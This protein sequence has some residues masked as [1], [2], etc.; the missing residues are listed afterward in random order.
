MS[1]TAEDIGEI[2]PFASPAALAEYLPYGH[3][4]GHYTRVPHLDLINDLLVD[5]TFGRLPEGNGRYL[6]I[7]IMPQSGKSTLDCH[8][9]PVWVNEMIAKGILEPGTLGLATYEGTLARSWGRHTRETISKNY[10]LLDCRIDSSST[11]MDEWET[12]TRGGMIARGIGGAF[13]GRPAR[14]MVVDDPNK[15]ETIFSKEA[16]DNAWEWW[17]GVGSQRLHP[18]APVVVIQARLHEDDFTGRLLSKDHEGDPNDWMVVRIPAIAEVPNE[19]DGIPPDPLGRKPGEPLYR[20]DWKPDKKKML[21]FINQKMREVG[22]IRALGQYQQR[23]GAAGGK[24]FKRSK[25][26]YWRHAGNAEDRSGIYLLDKPDRNDP[27]KVRMRSCIRFVIGDL[28]ASLD[29]EADWTVFGL[30]D[31]TPYWDLILVDL[32]RDRI[33][34]PDQITL[35]QSLYKRWRPAF[36]GLESAAYQLT[37][38]QHAKR[39]GVLVQEVKAENDKYTRALTAEA[40]MSADAVYFPS[41]AEWLGVFESELTGFPTAAH[42][43]QVDVLAHA[44]LAAD[45]YMVNSGWSKQ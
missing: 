36:V 22:S 9:Y 28:A 1:I 38:V 33:E 13:T 29:E 45:D 40:R 16:R 2:A 10:E 30:F 11:A 12:T 6:I 41:Q 44:A 7:N 18:E 3:I 32:V 42:D 27:V 23:P 25:F 26:R 15:A 39:R 31:L 34:G 19:K 35:L 43:D 24:L 4:S 17:L 14:R 37:A 21:T 8:W 5:A 20:P